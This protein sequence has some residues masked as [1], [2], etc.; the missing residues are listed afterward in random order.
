MRTLRIPLNSRKYPGLYAI[1]DELDADLVSQYRWHPTWCDGKLYAEAYVRGSGRDCR[2]TMRMHRLVMS[3]GAGQAIDHVNG[4]GLDNRRCNLRFSTQSQNLANIPKLRGTS[5][6]KGVYWDKSRAKWM[7]R[8][9]LS[10]VTK[11]LGRFDCEE[12]AA[13]AYDVAAYK[14]FGEFAVLNFPDDVRD[15]DGIGWLKI[16]LRWEQAESEAA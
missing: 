10:G 12:D 13:K 8:V 11:N 3:A 6:Y 16:T 14:E 15:P 4:D 1:V 9:R 5:R 7:A 2:R